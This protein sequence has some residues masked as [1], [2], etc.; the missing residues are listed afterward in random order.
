MEKEESGG[1]KKERLLRLQA[2][3]KE[4]REKMKAHR[5]N[6]LRRIQYYCGNHYS[7]NATNLPTPYNLINIA[8]GVI[9]GL[10][11][12]NNP[13]A[14][15]LTTVSDLFASADSL[16]QGLNYT[17]K[18][19]NL[20]N[21][22]Q[23]CIKEAL[24]AVGIVKTGLNYSRTE[25]I[26]GVLH[27]VGQP[28]AEVVS[29]QDF[30]IDMDAKNWETAQYMGNQF[31]I[32]LQQLIKS[33]LYDPDLIK[34]LVPTDIREINQDEPEP[35]ELDL[36]GEGVYEIQGKPFVEM[37]YLWEMYLP[38][39]GIVLTY[40]IENAI[41]QEIREIEWQGP[42]TGSYDM[43]SFDDVPGQVI[44]L[45]P[46]A[47]WESG[48]DILNTLLSKLRDQSLRQKRITA[49]TSPEDGEQIR[50][51]EDGE[52]IVKGHGDIQNVDVGGI[53]QSTLAFLVYNDDLI[54]KLVGNL[55]ALAGWGPQSD[56][57]GQDELIT[58][59]AIKQIES[60]EDRTR[61]FTTE[62]VRK[63][64]YYLFYDPAV[65]I[66]IVKTDPAGL[67]S[68]PINL[69]TDMIEGDF[70]EY[71]YAIE[72]HSMRPQPLG[73]KAQ[74]LRDILT[75]ILLPLQPML[76]QQGKGID[77]DFFMETMAEYDNLPELKR[78]LV[79]IDP[80]QAEQA[81]IPEH[82][83]SPVT[84]RNYTRRSIPG[85]TD[86]GKK[87]VLMRTLMGAGVQS[88]EGAAMTRPIG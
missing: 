32:P 62:V 31:S 63:L 64:A 44:P 25:E 3:V 71:N 51:R 47:H 9:A 77:L 17:I 54:N 78:M 74:K 33:G 7:D 86:A 79:D 19:A 84:Q 22:M 20:K 69:Q 36:D 50:D 88:S 42:E 82:G 65:N 57:L 61:D 28:Y 8:T 56:T 59:G 87:D 72:V 2:A 55:S 15:V 27:D 39:E 48:H 4:S 6:R 70:L 26:G 38:Q 1:V 60:M 12:A 66:P 49:V 83:K 11:A 68:I 35:F 30:V 41:N 23:R 21:T 58:S 13:K 52:I 18:E 10:L 53:D 14:T 29:I 75:Q 76:Q 24:L 73:A 80:S 5:N 46:A 34:K 45:P 16:K 40:P 67:I 43:L 81:A 85:A 37:V